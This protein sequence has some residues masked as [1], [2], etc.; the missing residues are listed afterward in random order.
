MAQGQ[1]ADQANSLEPA[2]FMLQ[3][4]SK[5]DMLVDSIV[6]QNRIFEKNTTLM[7]ISRWELLLL[8]F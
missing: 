3:P 1:P 6:E 8:R 2:G 4:S 5:A 7:Q